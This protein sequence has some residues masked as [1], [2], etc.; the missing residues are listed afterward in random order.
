MI[1]SYYEGDC[2]RNLLCTCTYFGNALIL[3]LRPCFVLF[4][5]IMSESDL[6]QQT[7]YKFVSTFM[8][9]SLGPPR[10]KKIFL[11]LY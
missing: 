10:K 3:E 6:Q 1:C 4:S 9:K 8:A 7:S 5:T 2:L 11:F